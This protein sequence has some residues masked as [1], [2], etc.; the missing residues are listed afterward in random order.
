MDKG[1]TIGVIAGAIGKEGYKDKDE[2]EKDKEERYA[3]Y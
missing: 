2:K 3:W 1:E